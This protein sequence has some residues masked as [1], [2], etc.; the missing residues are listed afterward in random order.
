MKV[1]LIQ[2]TKSEISWIRKGSYSLVCESHLESYNEDRRLKFNIL[3]VFDDIPDQM[4]MYTNNEKTLRGLIKRQHKAIK[5]GKT[6]IERIPIRKRLV[7]GLEEI[8]KE[9]DR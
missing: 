4:F 5:I 3:K 6:H 8:K 1:F 9:N 2:I 7:E